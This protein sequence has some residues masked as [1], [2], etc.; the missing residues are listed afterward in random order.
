MEE[1]KKG[2][3]VFERKCDSI[4]LSSFL[5]LTWLSA[6]WFSSVRIF[7][8]ISSPAPNLFSLYNRVCLLQLEASCQ[9]RQQMRE[10]KLLSA[11]I[12]PVIKHS[13]NK[14]SNGFRLLFTKMMMMS[15]E[16]AVGPSLGIWDCKGSSFYSVFLIQVGISGS[17]DL[18]TNFSGHFFSHWHKIATLIS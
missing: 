3:L 17:L 1:L 6:S 16:I 7:S 4:S 8:L 10:N 13:V 11:A 9:L 5:V 12:I 15:R 2:E 14:I 18:L